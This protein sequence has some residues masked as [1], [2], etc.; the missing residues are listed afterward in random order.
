MRYITVRR[1]KEVCKDGVFEA[2]VEPIRRNDD[3][4]KLYGAIVVSGIGV[5]ASTR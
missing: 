1:I 2:R 5:H 4:E 3:A